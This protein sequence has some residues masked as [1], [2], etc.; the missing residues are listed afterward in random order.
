MGGGRVGYNE[1]KIQQ[2]AIYE[3]VNTVINHKYSR[4]A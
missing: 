4:N 3:Y 2:Y 1:I